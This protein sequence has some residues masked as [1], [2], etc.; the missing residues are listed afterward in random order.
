MT[1]SSLAGV[2]LAGGRSRRMVGRDKV[3]VTLAGRPITRHVIDRV[4][5]QVEAL[6]LSVETISPAFEAFGLVQ[7]PDPSPGHN[8]P[9]GGLLSALRYFSESYEWVLLVPCDAPFVPLDLS[10]KLYARASG[11]GTPC[12]VIEYA[13]ELQPTFSIWHRSLQKE[14]EQAV[15]L[16]GFCGFKQFLQTIP[17]AEYRWPTSDP[18]PFFNVNDPETL[19]QAR[20]WIRNTEKT[21]R[22][23]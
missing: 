20:R 4:E 7:L 22:T 10:V 23:C 18:P 14:L 17:A 9:L 15:C 12:A 8:G 5:A 6:A 13:G 2:I 19:E 11:E 1:S 16:D 21:V 3:F